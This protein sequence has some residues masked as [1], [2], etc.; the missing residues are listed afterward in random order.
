MLARKRREMRKWA[1]SN[2]KNKKTLR[3]IY[4]FKSPKQN[5]NC[6]NQKNK[7]CPPFFSY[8]IPPQ[9]YYR[10][11]TACNDEN[12]KIKVSKCDL[13]KTNFEIKNSVIKRIDNKNGIHNPCY[14][15]TYEKYY[16]DRNKQFIDHPEEYKQKKYR[17]NCKTSFCKKSSLICND[18]QVNKYSNRRF[19]K[20]HAVNSGSH[21]HR[22]KYQAITKNQA[23]NRIS[24]QNI[25]NG[26]YPASLYQPTGPTKTVKNLPKCTENN[27]KYCTKVKKWCY[28]PC[29]CPCN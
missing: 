23:T 12:S 1:E 9:K 15:H 14:H 13:K 27:E 10:K 20:Q 29:N 18:I 2:I 22:L 11:E 3:P 24:K 5:I 16:V 4:N 8:G 21:L 26:T 7:P 6:M 28:P 25:M 17:E 19:S